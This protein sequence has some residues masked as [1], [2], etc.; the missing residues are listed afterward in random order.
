MTPGVPDTLPHPSTIA[1]RIIAGELDALGEA[2]LTRYL[3]GEGSVWDLMAAADRVRRDRFGDKVHLC[4]IVNAKQGGCPEDCGF[5]SQSKHFETSIKAEKFL[6]PDEIVA[7]SRKAESQRATALGLVTATRGMNEGDKALEHVLAGVKAVREAGHTEAHAS[8]GFVDEDGL[9]ALVDAGLTELNHNLETGRSYFPEIVSSHS[10]DARVETVR[11]AK[12]MG[13]RTCCGGIFGMGEAPEHRAELAMTLR[14]LDVDEVPLNFLIS[15][16]G[17]ALSARHF[18]PLAPMEMLRII[19]CYRLALPRQ[20]IFIAAGR[21]HLGQALPMM[22][23]AGASGMM[24]GDFLT[25]PNRGVEDDLRMI[26]ELGLET[27]VCG[28]PRPELAP[29]ANASASNNQSS[30]RVALPVLG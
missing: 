11:M 17:T 9:R 22:F 25:T 6:R 16:E 21:T 24:V 27:Q 8:L 20:N 29:A 4:S 10:Y 3:A 14:E 30:G 2:T 19:A 13:L 5:C 7:A 12:Q 26:E 1:D 28:D 15:I 23:S 18:E